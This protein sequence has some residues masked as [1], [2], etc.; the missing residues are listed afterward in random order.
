MNPTRSFLWPSSLYGR[1]ILLAAGLVG[2]GGLVV[3]CCWSLWPSPAATPPMISL[4]GVEKP[5]A[6][7][8]RTAREQVEEQPRSAEAWGQLGKLLLAHR[9]DREADQCFAQAEKLDAAQPRWPYYQGLLAVQHD[10]QWALAH[11][12]RAAQLEEQSDPGTF[13]IRL[14]LA[15]VLLE[16]GQDAEAETMLRAI[17][18]KDA[19]NPHL[20]YLWGLLAL[21]RDDLTTAADYLS[22]L[23]QHPCVR[24]KVCAQLAVIASRQKQ[25]AR[26]ESFSRLAEQL[27]A[28]AAW[29]DR[30]VQEYQQLQVGAY[31]RLQRLRAL[32]SEGKLREVM[33][34]LDSI[35]KDSDLANPARGITLIRLGQLEEAEMVLR[36]ALARAPENV[37][38]HFHLGIVL[39]M[40][41][42]QTPRGDSGLSATARAQYREAAKHFQRA[43][44][45]KPDHGLAHLNLGRVLLALGQRD[46]GIQ[47]LRTAI[48]CK[49]EE[50]GA[51]FF[52]AEALAD[53]GQIEEGRQQLELATRLAGKNP[54]SDV[55]S[56]LQRVRE[57]LGQAK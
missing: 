43:V 32:E 39:F 48:A 20:V 25:E 1:V 26:A 11:L 44:Q 53:A 45:L 34:V 24:K 33:S 22:R 7:A 15:E 27:P 49:P 16:Q 56:A 6:D 14:R 54:T 35:D 42:D 37:Q 50:A 13:V 30:Y 40:R 19:R 12:R 9:F 47:E 28:D 2:V 5:I 10:S 51:H 29:E 3:F 21:V 41:A 4:E 23:T 57:K 38:A 46:E 17:A 52:L 18:A 31:G 8:I 36:Q 55:A